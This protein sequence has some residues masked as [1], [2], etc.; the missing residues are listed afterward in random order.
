M[1][2]DPDPDY[3]CCDKCRFWFL[4]WDKGNILCPDCWYEK[5]EPDDVEE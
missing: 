3:Y 5:Y 1:D 2:I 4:K